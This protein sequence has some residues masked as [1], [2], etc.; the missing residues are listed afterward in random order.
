MRDIQA[1]VEVRALI[2]AEKGVPGMTTTRLARRQGLDGNPLRRH[3]DI[4]AAPAG[5][6]LE[7]GR[8]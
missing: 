3:S 1:S 4:N 8:G 5:A 2:E 7:V 6:E